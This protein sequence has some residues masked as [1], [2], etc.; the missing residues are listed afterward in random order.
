MAV[1][2]GLAPAQIILGW[3]YTRGAGVAKSP[4]QASKWFGSAAKQGHPPEVQF[5]LGQCY[6]TG[7]G[8]AKDLALGKH[9]YR[10]AAA[11]GSEKAA[12]RLKNLS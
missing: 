9:W 4:S 7:H 12:A 10:K 6:E 5:L 2:Q 1:A 8:V 11:N 3:A